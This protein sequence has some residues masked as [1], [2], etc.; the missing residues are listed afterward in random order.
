VPVAQHLL[1]LLDC[2]PDML[3][4]SLP[5]PEFPDDLIAPLDV[6]LHACEALVRAQVRASVFAATGQRDALGLYCYNTRPRLPVPTTTATTKTTT[7]SF[8]REDYNDDEEEHEDDNDDDYDRFVHGPLPSTAHEIVPLAPPGKAAVQTLQAVQDHPVR[9]RRIDLPQLYGHRHVTS[10]TTTPTTPTTTAPHPLQTALFHALQVFG[11]AKCVRKTTP[12]RPADWQHVWI[13]TNN[14]HPV[15]SDGDDPDGCSQR[16]LLQTA[17][18]D[19][20][21]A[22]IDVTVWPLPNGPD[23]DNVDSSVYEQLEMDVAPSTAWTLLVDILPETHRQ[24]K[25]AR[26]AVGVPLL[27][28]D[29]K[30]RPPNDPNIQL[31][32]YRLVQESRPPK[33]YHVHQETGR[34]LEK[35]TQTVT[36]RGSEL[37][38]QS[39]GTGHAKNSWGGGADRIQTYVE[40]G[41]EKIPM[42]YADR[43][44]I[45]RSCNANPDFASLILLG[46]HDDQS[47]PLAHTMERSYFCVPDEESVEGST[48]AFAH[49]HASMLR[50]KVVA[51]GEL[52]TKVTAAARLVALV[53]LPEER[54][55][56]H[57][58]DELPEILRPAGM[59]VVSLPFEDEVR[60]LDDDEATNVWEATGTDVAS[61]DLVKAATKLIQRQIIDSIRIGENFENAALL[62]MW[63]YI[64]HVALEEPMP[65]Q[66]ASE[67]ILDKDL[68][69]ERARHEIDVF[70]ANLPDDS[71]VEKMPRKR[72]VE[73]DDSRL[74]WCTIWSR[75]QY[76]ECTNSDLKKKLRSC[77]EKVSGK[78]QDLI[79]RLV[80]ILEN[81]FGKR[82]IKSEPL[83]TE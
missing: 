82:V 19:A 70:L 53:P 56:S 67:T 60:E 34:A 10:P 69:L 16:Q 75:D 55:D 2:G 15:S 64:E 79:D 57:F 18:H 8:P 73:P 48:A 7:T 72:K 5:D 36:V 28:P 68:V 58:D 38:E 50:K 4:A 13:F 46:F 45:R 20:A 22:G 65:E 14:A 61:P 81:E 83:L 66:P 63:N 80:P 24:W 51:V 3:R 27:L 6:V 39:W 43:D 17:L 76:F 44:A 31:N 25:Q 33:Q 74:D 40:F 9:G 47:I 11:R 62:K 41:G 71:I 23:Q 35:L 52:L 37:L 49:L 26:R 29:W 12:T 78:K 59:L 1:I 42:S 54:V 77:G 32:L 21:E 30:E